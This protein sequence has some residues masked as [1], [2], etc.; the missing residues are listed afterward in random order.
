V[1]G[2]ALAFLIVIP[3]GNLRWPLL[4][5]FWLSF[6]RNLLLDCL[7]TTG[8]V[9]FVLKGMGFS[10]SVNGN[11]EGAALAAE[12]TPTG[13]THSFIHTANSGAL[14]QPIPP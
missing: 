12:G 5:L 2:I 7:H 3:E 1:A 6:R 13:G 11:E 10:P 8:E 9:E 4:L 14:H